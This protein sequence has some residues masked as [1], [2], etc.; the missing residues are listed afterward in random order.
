MGVVR[1]SPGV[2]MVCVGLTLRASRRKGKELWKFNVYLCLYIIS[3]ANGERRWKYES[4][5]RLREMRE[6][7][8]NK[9][10]EDEEVRGR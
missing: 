7:R 1:G 2:V 6:K 5:R 3:I 4:R 8:K 9:R 10:D